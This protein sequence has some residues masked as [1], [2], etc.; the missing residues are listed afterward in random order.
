VSAL[1]IEPPSHMPLIVTVRCDEM[2][3]SE[4]CGETYPHSL[5]RCPFCGGNS[6]DPLT[7]D[8]ETCASAWPCAF[9]I[10]DIDTAIRAWAAGD[11]QFEAA[12]EIVLRSKLRT[13]ML[14]R[15]AD[16]SSWE[17]LAAPDFAALLRDADDGDAYLSSSER[18]LL[19]IAA[20]IACDAILP[21]LRRRPRLAVAR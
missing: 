7:V 16:W 17:F 15:Y 13:K 21:A 1:R 2:K 3:D 8:C 18:T 5:A 12:A 10:D 4:R 11:Y 14:P 19:T 6:I 9:A 20:N